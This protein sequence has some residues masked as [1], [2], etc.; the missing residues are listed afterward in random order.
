M[1]IRATVQLLREEGELAPREVAARLGITPK[2]AAY[3]LAQAQRLGIVERAIKARYRVVD[4]A[5][6]V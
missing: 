4:S 3:R 1:G 5:P 6:E 2:L